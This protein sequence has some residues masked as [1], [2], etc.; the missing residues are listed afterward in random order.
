MHW[1]KDKKTTSGE[2]CIFNED[3]EDEVSIC[4]YSLHKDNLYV[5]SS[6]I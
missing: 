5:T 3:N 6:S 4:Y 2:W 1:G